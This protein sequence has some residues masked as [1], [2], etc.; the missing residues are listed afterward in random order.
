MS[1]ECRAFVP[2]DTVICSIESKI[3]YYSI[4]DDKENKCTAID[5]DVIYEIIVL[6]SYSFL[7]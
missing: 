6:F 7:V 2:F 3:E 1:R 4:Y 5:M